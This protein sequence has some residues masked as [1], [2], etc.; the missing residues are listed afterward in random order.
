M[1]FALSEEHLIFRDMVRKFAEKEMAPLVEESEEKQKFPMELWGKWA[2]IGVLGLGYPEEVGGTPADKLYEAILAE[3]FGRVSQGLLAGPGV[4]SI[5]VAPLVYK[6]G[7]KEQQAKYLPPVIQ[8]KETFAV[9]ITEPNCGSDVAA[10]QTTAVK[11]GD[12]YIINGAKTFIT[13]GT[14]SDHVIVVAKTQ[15]GEGKQGETLF[16]VDKGTP[17]FLPPKKLK[18]LGWRSSETAELYFEDCRVPAENMLG[19]FNRGFYHIMQMFVT[20]RILLGAMSIGLARACYEES[21]KYAKERKAFGRPIGTLQATGF[22]L[23]DMAAH[24][25]MARLLTY[26]ACW[27]YDQGKDARKEACMAKCY[28]SEFATN[29]A[30]EAV[31]IHGGYGFMEEYP[32]SRYFRD[33]KVLQ[34][35]GGP[36]EIQKGI[37]LQLIG[38]PEYT[39]SG[40]P[41]S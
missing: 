21:M 9:G 18:K 28:A 41:N 16:I 32:V 11:D 39:H 13:N 23:V 7:N 30:V 27:L 14:F 2:E 34:I 24:I 10:I 19:E 25:E 37:V 8:G 38:F 1:N 33:T 4:S 6:V 35:G 5:I 31:Q 26:K 22:K 20:E 17:G 12:H 29:A 40:I 36:S 15:K 3:E